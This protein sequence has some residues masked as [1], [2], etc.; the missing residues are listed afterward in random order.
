MATGDEATPAA[1]A[2]RLW[3][4]PAV[5]WRLAALVLAGLPQ[6]LLAPWPLRDTGD[7]F[8]GLDG[9]DGLDGVRTSEAVDTSVAVAVV[10][11]DP[12]EDW[13]D[14]LAT[15]G[16]VLLVLAVAFMLPGT[17]GRRATFGALWL[18]AALGVLA[19]FLASGPLLAYC[20]FYVAAAGVLA[21]AGVRTGLSSRA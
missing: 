6:F 21:V 15:S 13:L 5:G 10:K 7:A 17:A 4:R 1:G 20:V 12:A 3:A 2:A 19:G 16:L 8:D 11:S 14:Y 18:L 9:L